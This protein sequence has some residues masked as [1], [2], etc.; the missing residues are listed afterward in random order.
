MT[1]GGAKTGKAAAGRLKVFRGETEAA[2][3]RAAPSIKE[4]LAA[5]PPDDRAALMRAFDALEPFYVE[6]APG[7]FVGAHTDALPHLTCEEKAGSF[8]AG[9][10]VKSTAAPG[11]PAGKPRA[12]KPKAKKV[13]DDRD[14]TTPAR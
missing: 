13:S 1:S 4:I 8:R 14:P 12:R 9:R 11:K 5:L 2:P 10:I 3:P 7:R 6:Y